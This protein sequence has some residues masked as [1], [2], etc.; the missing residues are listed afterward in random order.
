MTQ[1]VFGFSLFLFVG[2][3]VAGCVWVSEAVYG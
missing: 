2:L 3:W 1:L